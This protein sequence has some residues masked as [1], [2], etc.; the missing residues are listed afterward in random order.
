[1]VDTGLPE[2]PKSGQWST[3]FVRNAPRDKGSIL[4]TPAIVGPLALPGDRTDI[5]EYHDCQQLISANGNGASYL[6]LF[7]IF[8][9]SHLGDSSL[10]FDAV[11]DTAKTSNDSG[12]VATSGSPLAVGEIYAMG[13]DYPTLGV[14]K[15]FNCLFLYGKL[16]SLNGLEAKVIPVAMDETKCAMIGDPSTAMGTILEVHRHRFSDTSNVP[17]VARWD[18]DSTHNKQHIGIGCG[19]AWCDIGAPGFIA[20]SAHKTT[21]TNPNDRVLAVKG[22][23]D[24]QRLAYPATASLSMANPKVGDVRGTLVAAPGLKFATADSF[25]NQWYSVATVAIP[26]SNTYMKKLNLGPSSIANMT[27]SVY[28]CNGS[29]STCLPSGAAISSESCTGSNPMWWTKIVSHPSDA[30]DGGSGLA[31]APTTAYYCVT[32]RTHPGMKIPGVVRWRWF[33]KDETMWISCIEGCCEV[34][35]GSFY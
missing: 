16:N 27:D 34:E 26:S 13:G 22:W 35:A 5:P 20:S 9:R 29:Q 4:A 8:S 11:L 32:R 24:E 25:K 18:W 3:R 6:P 21:I 7:A 1:M 17:D 23:Y 2:C 14:K 30:S 15:G 10:R 19:S 33:I 12:L 31:A 28:L